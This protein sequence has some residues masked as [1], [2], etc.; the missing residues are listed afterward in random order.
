M[1]ERASIELNEQ[2]DG[3]WIGIAVVDGEEYQ[4]YAPNGRDCLDKLRN[5]IVTELFGDTRN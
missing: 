2:D 3:S 4:A 1:N 5:R